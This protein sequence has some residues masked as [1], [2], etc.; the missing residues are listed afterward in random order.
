MV[1]IA[2]AFCRVFFVY[3]GLGGFSFCQF[4]G[5]LVWG[6]LLFCFVSLCFFC[7]FVFYILHSSPLIQM[8]TLSLFWEKRKGSNPAANNII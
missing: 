1:R 2:L 4:G 7:V 8:P 3:F 5:F 6:G